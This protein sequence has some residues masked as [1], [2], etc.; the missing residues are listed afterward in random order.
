MSNAPDTLPPVDDWRKKAACDATTTDLFFPVGE[1]PL[2]Q[3][4][5]ANAKRICHT[6][7]VMNT[8]LRWALNEHQDVGVWGGLDERERQKIHRRR[9]SHNTPAKPPRT[10]ESIL[11]E[12]S[13]TVTGGH[14]TWSGS[15]PVSFHG[16]DFTPA[17]LA[18]F[19]AHKVRPAGHLRASCGHPGCIAAEHRYETAAR[20]N[21][22]QPATA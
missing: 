8:C 13:V 12:R 19:V 20:V 7:P 5:T 11:A 2:A 4:Q 6:C 15:S 17:Q 3:Q 22:Q 18:W 10:P 16:W 9:L 14:I 21:T 1:G